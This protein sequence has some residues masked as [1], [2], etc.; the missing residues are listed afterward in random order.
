MSGYDDRDTWG[1]WDDDP[2]APGSWPPS[3][4]GSLRAPG[5]SRHPDEYVD[6]DPAPD[7]RAVG[8][9]ERERIRAR[10]RAGRCTFPVGG[11]GWVDDCV[12][13]HPREAEEAS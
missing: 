2:H 4:G 8:P 5:V 7:E 9:V 11:C 13:H 3:Y 1:D 10:V 6:P 12:T